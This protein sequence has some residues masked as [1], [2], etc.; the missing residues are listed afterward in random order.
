MAKK[1]ETIATT[2]EADRLYIVWLA[3]QKRVKYLG[4]VNLKVESMAEKD[5]KAP[6]E[7]MT[8]GKKTA[9]WT[10]EFDFDAFY[11]EF[12]LVI[13]SK[14]TLLAS[15]KMNTIGDMKQRR[16]ILDG[17]RA[18]TELVSQA[19]IDK[20]FK[21]V[22]ERAAKSADVKKIDD[23][24][25]SEKEGI[26]LDKE[27]VTKLAKSVENLDRGQRQMDLEPIAAKMKL[28]GYVRFVYGLDAGFNPYALM[29][30]HFLKGAAYPLPSFPAAIVAKLVQEFGPDEKG[31]PD[32]TAARKIAGQVVD[33]KV[34]PVYRKQMTD[35]SNADIKKRTEKIR[36]LVEKR[37][38]AM[39]G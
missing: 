36:Q 25:K 5:F 20:Y 27:F 2:K 10:W 17:L 15:A 30:G 39:G 32:F 37:K 4:L 24:I 21:T 28:A 3:F 1:T 26:D 12:N 35:D 31:Q 11:F 38:K 13:G 16:E 34:M 9:D 7:E 6:G 18:G 19:E 8:K 33:A 14:K 22:Q 23:E 29:K